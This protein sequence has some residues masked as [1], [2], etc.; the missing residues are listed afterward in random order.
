MVDGA[1]IFNKIH[2]G[3]T[4][5]SIAARA[6]E[7][8]D[9]VK[10]P[11]VPSGLQGS[12]PSS[13]YNQTPCNTARNSR[14]RKVTTRRAGDCSDLGSRSQ[15]I[16]SSRHECFE[17]LRWLM[18]L[19]SFTRSLRKPNL[20]LR[21]GEWEVVDLVKDLACFRPPG[22]N[23]YH[24]NTQTPCNAASN[25]RERRLSKRCARDCSDL[26]IAVAN[27]HIDWA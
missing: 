5:P 18:V 14:E 16:I 11:A 22:S 19:G 13:H 23:R 6:W 2:Y 25:S 15:M 3:R 17:E 4:E 9:L 20:R 21:R 8:V 26:G 1:G 10:D 24:I 12:Q 7:V 27:D